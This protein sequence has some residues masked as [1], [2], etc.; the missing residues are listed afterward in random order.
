MALL[1]EFLLRVTFGLA[2]GMA[3]TS[4]RE[5][6]SGYFRNHLFVTFGLMVLAA[7]IAG[8]SDAH[9]WPSVVAA[10]ISYVGSVC[11]LYEAKR[12]GR[13]CLCLVAAA[14]LAGL[15]LHATAALPEAAAPLAP[16]LLR[17]TM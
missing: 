12:F 7:L 4:P 1:Y 13:T 5:V 9:V 15:T 11:W 3:V 8:S 2:L 16:R 6:T 14:A 17:Q 10:G